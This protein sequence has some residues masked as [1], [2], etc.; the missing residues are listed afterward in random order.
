MT[1]WIEQARQFKSPLRVVVGF[2]LRSRETQKERKRFWQVEFQELKQ[3]LDQKTRR[4]EEQA[5]EIARLKRQVR[6]LKRERAEIENKP[7]VLPD[8]PPVASHGYGARMISLAVNL[9]Q[10]VG[11]RGSERA[12][13]IFLTGWRSKRKFRT[14][15]RSA[16]G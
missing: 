11:L 15:L 13:K 16:T 1:S 6:E 4:I 2:L 9:A 10:G 3:Q 7:V 12:L 5:E 14:S 8:D